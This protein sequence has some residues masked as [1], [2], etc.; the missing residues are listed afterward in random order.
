[1]AA[2]GQSYSYSCTA[3]SPWFSRQANNCVFRAQLVDHSASTA[4]LKITVWHKNVED[5][6]LG[7]SPNDRSGVAAELAVG[8]ADAE[9]TIVSEDV[10]DLKE[11]IRFKYEWN[12]GIGGSS[13]DWVRT[14]MLTP[15]WYDSNRA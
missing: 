9:G 14:R 7:T 11:L 8:G 5:S 3:W 1:M 10:V 2:L 13:S 15:S 12:T 4:E 6:G